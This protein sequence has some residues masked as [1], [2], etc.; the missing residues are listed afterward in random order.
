MSNDNKSKKSKVIPWACIMPAVLALGVTACGGGSGDGSSATTSTTTTTSATTNSEGEVLSSQSKGFA[1][2]TEISAVPATTSSGASSPAVKSFKSLLKSLVNAKAASSLPATSDYA[3][4]TTKKFVEERSLEQFEI[5]EEIMGALAQTHYADAGNI[6]AGPYKAMISWIEDQNG[7]EI[8]TLQPWV[9]DSRMIIT[10]GPAGTDVD[11]NRVLAWIEEADDKTPGQTKLVKAE[12][13]IYKAAETAE[14]GAYLNYGEWD[15][16]VSFDDTATS[17]FAASARINASGASELMIHENFAEQSPAGD[18]EMKSRGI[19]V[20]SGTSGYGQVEFPDFQGCFSGTASPGPGC[21][22]TDT[23]KYA[24]NEGYLSVSSGEDADSDGQIDVAYKDRNLNNAV[25]MTHRYGLFAADTGENIEKTKSFGFPV[26]YED[27]SGVRRFAYYGAWQGR[28]MLWGEGL[29]A[30]TTVTREDMPGANKT[31]YTVSESFNG[32]LTKRAL[33]DVDLNDIKDI[34]VEIF[35]NKHYD[36][37]YSVGAN[38]WTY[39]DGRI[40]WMNGTQTCNDV[41]GAT[42]PMTAFNPETA[43]LV[44]GEN[45]R[46]FVNIGG[47]SGGMGSMPKQYVYLNATNSTGVS[48]YTSPG[49]YEAEWGDKGLRAISPAQKLTPSDGENL[50]V[51]VSGS[52]YV[53][54]KG[55]VASTTGWVQKTLESFDQSTWTPVFSATGDSDFSPEVGREY[56]INS[57]GANYVVKR[58]DAANDAT[59]YQAQ[60]ELQ[61]AANPVN[62]SSI[63]PAGADY[64]TTPWRKEVRYTLVTDASSANFLKL[65]YANDDPST[66]DEVETGQVVDSGQWGLQAFSDN[67]TPSDT[68][69]DVPLLADGSDVTVDHYG[70]PMDPTL[71]PVEFNWEYSSDGG[72][73]GQRYL[74]SGSDYVLL[75]NPIRLASTTLTNRAGDTKT[76]ALQFDGW[77]HGLPDMYFELSKNNFEMSDAIAA[78][79]LSIP[80]GTELT[81]ADTGAKYYVKPL[82][83]SIFLD[84]V[85]S[86]TTG[87]PDIT[88]ADQINLDNVPDFVNH[89]MGAMPTNVEVKYSE[90]KEVVQ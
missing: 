12:F 60:V 77:M 5:I 44:V 28:H 49:F 7:R 10:K 78:K 57:R 72:W 63:L 46:K 85:A 74:M 65:V 16:N 20:R 31:T 26:S 19:L 36:L 45:D 6:N 35:V 15:M 79:V 1:L 62:Y 61:M 68:S 8:K 52:L 84:E 39:C 54:Y 21:V 50:W 4:T 9:I 38:A 64:L 55:F 41:N 14:D 89:N 27:S 11:T 69:D 70:F 32:T 37:R 29:A 34:P 43:G 51:D 40:E 25:E 86:T 76:V 2:P 3:L 81:D 22:T 17:F 83:V 47:N 80:A 58:K 33:S 24:Y 75:S 42:Q 88:S 13:K 67:G 90:G 48:G 59:S 56:Y 23:A 73:G 82:E 30:G 18:M 71:R 66:S 53:E 87:L